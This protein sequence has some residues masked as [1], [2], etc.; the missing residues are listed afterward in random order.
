[1]KDIDRYYGIVL[2]CFLTYCNSYLSPFTDHLEACSSVRPHYHEV[3]VH[4]PAGFLNK[5]SR[6]IILGGGDNLL[7]HEV[8]KY[9]SLELA[10]ILELD[11]LVVRSAYQHLGAHPHWNDDRVKYYFGDA[12]KS[13]PM[14]PREYYGTFDIVFIDLQTWI[15]EM[16]GVME[17]SSKLIKPGGFIM[18]NEDGGFGTNDEFARHLVDIYT[19]NIPAWCAQGITM[20]SNNV[21]VFNR[22]W[23]PYENISNLFFRPQ[24]ET[25]HFY[26]WYSY[27]KNDDVCKESDDDDDKEGGNDS[28]QSTG[29]KKAHSAS[30]ILMIIEAENIGIS[31]EPSSSV[32]SILSGAL[33]KVGFNEVST[34]EFSFDP[35][36]SSSG[37]DYTLVR[38]MSEGYVVARISP[39]HKYAALDLMLW[40]RF[41]K[42]EI[43]KRHIVDAFNIGD[44]RKK[45][46]LV[47]SYRIVTGG[48]IGTSSWDEDRE[49]LGP[50]PEILKPCDPAEQKSPE[51]RDGAITQKDI[52]VVLDES[53]ALIRD[54]NAEALVVV[55]CGERSLSPLCNAK[56]IIGKGQGFEVA[57]IVTCP[58]LSDNNDT[59]D[60]S[61]LYACEMD[62]LETLREVV[63][64]ENKS[65]GGIVID[66]GVPHAMGQVLNKIFSDVFERNELLQTDFSVVAIAPVES[67]EDL[68]WKWRRAFVDRFRTK[69]VQI[70]PAFSADISFDN[71]DGSSK[72]VLDM[73]YTADNKEFYPFLDGIVKRIEAE[74][75]LSA[76]IKYVQNGVN[77]YLAEFGAE[78]VFTD[79]Q[80]REIQA[81]LLTKNESVPRE[82]FLFGGQTIFQFVVAD[83]N[84][85]ASMRLS[86]SRVRD[87]VRRTLRLVR[88][89][90]ASEK[91]DTVVHDELGEGCIVISAWSSGNAVLLWNG[92]RS[93]DVNLFMR[94][95]ETM[96]IHDE[97]GAYMKKY[98]PS[99][100]IVLRDDQPRGVGAS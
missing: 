7:I 32:R 29:D 36:D 71:S 89:G 9:K 54:I 10:V 74:T 44:N 3:M 78:E 13:L 57:T 49:K 1:M 64:A 51:P 63:E 60:S 72:A 55:V 67:I 68:P 37:S 91:V 70:G 41:D 5:V 30:G 97:F 15:I 61:L 6:V 50:P 84:M 18:R 31:L 12:A 26:N 4:Y 83:E 88:G 59:I 77:A 98:I 82:E 69:F 52:D 21:D 100:Q 76:D 24:E 2:S 40:G 14:L 93:L 19:P 86:C 65:I 25:S 73:F 62:T 28:S 42:Q 58:N 39:K 48:M 56:N 75:K 47:T 11:Q 38:V 66:Q 90:S 33:E 85:G 94:G 23:K 35:K 27:R 46:N 43:A 34:K 20:G 81:A 22:R 92:D 53:L 95:G 17:I 8:M 79:S 99:L 45:T 87:A 80:Y 16:L 96:S